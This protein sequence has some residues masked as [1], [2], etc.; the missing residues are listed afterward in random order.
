MCY[1]IVSNDIGL[2]D[3]RVAHGVYAIHQANLVLASEVQG[4]FRTEQCGDHCTVA[5]TDHICSKVCA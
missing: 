2:T 4:Y 5:G 3:D 1:A